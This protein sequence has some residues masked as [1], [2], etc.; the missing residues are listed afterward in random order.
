MWTG[1][2]GKRLVVGDD[3]EVVQETFAI[4]GDKTS[5]S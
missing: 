2:S 4:Y 5:V 1:T 3:Q